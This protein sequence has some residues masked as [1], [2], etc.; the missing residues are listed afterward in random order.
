MIYKK[1]EDITEGNGSVL[2][3]G[4]NWKSQRMLLKNDGMGFSFNITTIF[5]GTETRIWYKNHVEAVYCIFGEGEVETLSDGK[6][7]RI[8]PGALY[9]LDGNEEH[10]LRARTELR[11]ACV[12][13]PPLRGDEVHDKDGSYSVAE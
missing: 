9:A 1:L 13:N 5:A 10:L 12:F 7:Y 2:D 4:G 8:S 6:I 11:L 3:P